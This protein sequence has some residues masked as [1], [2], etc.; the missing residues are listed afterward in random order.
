MGN[1]LV[2]ISCCTIWLVGLL[3]ANGRGHLRYLRFGLHPGLICH[4][5]SFFWLPT[6]AAIADYLR[7]GVHHGLLLPPLF[8]LGQLVLALA[9]TGLPHA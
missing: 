2:T 4:V 8:P 7:R 3:A 6:A 9:F 1:H 5:L